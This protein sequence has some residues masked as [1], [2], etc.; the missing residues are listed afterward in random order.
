MKGSDTVYRKNS[1]LIIAF[2]T[3]VTTTLIVGL[4]VAY[5]LTAQKVEGD[6]AVKKNNVADQ[7]VISPY[8][9][10]YRNKIFEINAYS[11]LLDSVSARAYVDSVFRNFKFVTKIVFY[12]VVVGSQPLTDITNNLSVTAR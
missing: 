12:Q 3:L 8:N 2:L 10:L 1:S 6:F 9:D 7:S 11:G 5:K 4:F